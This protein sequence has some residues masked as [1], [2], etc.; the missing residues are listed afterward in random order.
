MVDKKALILILILVFFLR[1][2]S[3]FEP[4]TYG[5]EGVYLTL[6]Q[7]MRRGV[8]LYR[9]IHDNKPPLLYL[10]AALAGNFAYF[11]L[12]NFL[13]SFLTIGIFWKLAQRL[14][15][16]NQPAIIVSTGLFAVLTSMHT[17]EGNVANAEN[18]M[19]LPIIGGFWLILNDKHLGFF[20][21]GILFSLA[22]LFKIPAA[23]DFLA[24]LTFCFLLFLGRKKKNY[25]LFIIRN[26][27][28]IFGFSLPFLITFVYFAFQGALQ[29]YLAAAIFQNIP[30]LSSWTADKPQALGL[31]LSLLGRTSLVALV[32]LALFIWKKKISLVAKLTL[33]WFSFS[34]FA[35]LLSSRPYPHYL[36]Q[37]LPSLSLAFGLIFTPSKERVVPFFLSLVLTLSFFGFHFWHYPNLSYY[38]N[39][40]QYALRM[41]SHE[42]YF[43]FFEGQAKTIYQVAEYIQTHTQPEERIFIWGNQP[44]LY[45]L[46]R[47]LPVGRYTVAYHIIDFDGYQ[48]TIKDLR[49]KEPSLIVKMKQVKKKFPDFENL[50]RSDYLK[51]STMGEAEIYQKL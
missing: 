21:S 10:F 9:E 2:P 33:I 35:A 4:F 39:F 11:R 20:F 6:G 40:Y 50:L 29:Q 14:F 48:E 12:L 28:F 27:L 16:Q 15:P 38:L 25:S 13:W 34:L 23:F 43:A 7:A 44:S 51:V 42:E 17:F 8:V 24:A 49:E 18:F 41:K 30:Y 32:V 5:D 1:L 36:L 19:L 37:A 22:A 47:R 3:L 46:A 26:S 31:P 45:A